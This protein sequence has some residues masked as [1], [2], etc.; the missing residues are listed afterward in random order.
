MFRWLIL[1]L[2]VRI[3]FIMSVTYFVIS[4]DTLTRV[5]CGCAARLDLSLGTSPVFWHHNSV[6]ALLL[7][8]AVTGSLLGRHG[9]QVS[10]N[11]APDIY[12]QWKCVLNTLDRFLKT[13][14]QL[15]YCSEGI[16]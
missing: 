6:S 8:T 1:T 9:S 12:P 10:H 15:I 5:Y 3:W 16:R 7:R 2:C 4:M 13:V 11:L 14:L